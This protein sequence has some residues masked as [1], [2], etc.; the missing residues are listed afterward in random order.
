MSERDLNGG[1]CEDYRDDSDAQLDALLATADA[2]VLDKLT[3]ATD[4]DAGRAAAFAR[5][6]TAEEVPPS[7]EG[8]CQLEWLLPFNDDS[9]LRWLAISGPG[10]LPRQLDKA[11]STIRTMT[12]V[13][14]APLPESMRAY[15]GLSTDFLSEASSRL[16]RLKTGLA[17]HELTRDAALDLQDA[18]HTGIEQ[19]LGT[20]HQATQLP[21]DPRAG[22]VTERLISTSEMLLTLLG[23]ARQSVEQLFA[24]TDHTHRCPTR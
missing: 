13:G 15:W 5:S 18:A 22:R 20:L 21:H 12:V 3:Q 8:E 9:L 10:Y 6:V 4:L 16:T 2:A 7:G 17:Q 23:W 19:F 11:I 1:L 14:R 24:D